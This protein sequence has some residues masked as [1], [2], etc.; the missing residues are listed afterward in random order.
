MLFFA[1]MCGAAQSAEHAA[2][3]KRVVL[4]WTE[5]GKGSN[6]V[7]DRLAE[8]RKALG[9]VEI[10]QDRAKADAVLHGSAVLWTTGYVA[11]S[12]RSRA[13]EEPIYQG[14]ATA[15]LTALDGKTLWSYLATP[16]HQG[17][18]SITDDLADQLAST[19]SEALVRKEPRAG[20]PEAATGPT[21]TIPPLSS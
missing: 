13:A 17:W 2:G 7:R 4:D 12:P 6:A 21:T 3:I 19:L 15:E 5:G 9:K 14:Y 20:T 16:R 8:K 11:M 18:K 10:V 1:A